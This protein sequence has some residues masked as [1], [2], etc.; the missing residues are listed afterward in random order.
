M[1]IP[2]SVFWKM[3]LPRIVLLLQVGSGVQLTE[4]PFWV[5]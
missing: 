3:L 4:M 2:A 1:A 5:L